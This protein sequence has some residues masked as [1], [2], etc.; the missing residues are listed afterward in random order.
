M[1]ILKVLSLNVRGLNNLIKRKMLFKTFQNYDV[2]SLQETY[3]N[4]NNLMQW[5]QD[6]DGDLLHINGTTNSNG[7]ITLINKNLPYDNLT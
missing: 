3:V 2:C 7:L 4:E 6:W 5:K 1:S